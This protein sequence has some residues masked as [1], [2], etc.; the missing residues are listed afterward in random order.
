MERQV[1]RVLLNSGHEMPVIGFGTAI[2][3]LPEPEQ[4]VSAI[5]H[6]IE[7]GYRHFDT[8]SAYMTEE[9]VGRA[10]SEAM[11]RGLIKGREELFVTSKLWCAD[12]HRDLIIP[13]LKETLKR[14]GLD[15]L[16]LYLI[17]F[18][19][20][21]KKEAVSLEHEIDDFRFEDHEL[22]PFDI[23]GTWEA[24]EECSRLGLTKSIGVSN[25]GTVKISQLLQHA[26]IPP[27]VNQVEMNVAWQQKKLREFC[28]KKGIHVTAWSPLAG[29]GAFWGST[30]VIESK[31]LK[32][33]AAAKGKSVAQVA[34][35]WIQDQGASCIVKS[36]NKD[37]MKQN[38]EI[39]GWKLSDEDGRKIEQIKQSRL[40]PAKLF[41]NEN[42]PYPSLEALWDGDL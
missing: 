16:D 11:K 37:R 36:M 22:L 29:I 10:I 39:F 7:V 31:T 13:A 23:K 42:S 30:V 28:S 27:A 6:A 24:M 18:P 8:A 38:L 33:I 19:V 15:Y 26:T 9:P 25:Y 1:P 12:A 41:I 4:L 21:L 5:L 2:D 17:H 40:Y 20:R 34:L 3:P 32:E 14:L 35:R